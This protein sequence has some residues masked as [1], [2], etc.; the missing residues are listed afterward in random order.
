M[1]DVGPES[2]PLIVIPDRPD[3]VPEPEQAPEPQP[4]E[5]PA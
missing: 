4:V 3:F 2:E 5:Q 1:A